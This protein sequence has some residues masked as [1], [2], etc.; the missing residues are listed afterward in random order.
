MVTN[1]IPFLNIENAALNELRIVL[2]HEIKEEVIFKKNVKELIAK[3]KESQILFRKFLELIDDTDFKINYYGAD[4]E[5]IDK[6]GFKINDLIEIKIINANK[7][8]SDT[9]LSQIFNKIIKYRY[10]SNSTDILDN[11][12]A[13]INKTVTE[14]VSTSHTQSINE[15]LHKIEY[16]DRLKVYLSSDLDFNKLMN[17]LIKYEYTEEG[18]NIPEGQYGLGYSYLMSIIGE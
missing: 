13:K 12:I 6:K 16:S 8:I 14:Q 11:E 1:I 7:I 10:K 15:V 2:K 3:H 18:L 17:N 5:L 9:S 4:D